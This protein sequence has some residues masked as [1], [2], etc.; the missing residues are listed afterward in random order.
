MMA[1]LGAAVRDMLGVG[2]DNARRHP[3]PLDRGFRAI[4]G[5][6]RHH[7][8]EVRRCLGVMRRCRQETTS[9]ISKVESPA[10]AAQP[11]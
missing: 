3:L 8:D 10:S 2:A 9:E 6:H 5:D 1:R 4:R 7:S 11:R